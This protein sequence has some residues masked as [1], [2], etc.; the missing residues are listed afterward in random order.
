MK[1]TQPVRPS[2]IMTFQN[3]INI[4]MKSSKTII[5]KYH[6]LDVIYSIHTCKWLFYIICYEISNFID[7]HYTV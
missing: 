5:H 3:A 7:T 1:I 2:Y 6:G 4:D